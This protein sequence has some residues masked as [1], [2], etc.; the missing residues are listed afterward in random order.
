MSL[1]ITLTA[2]L[3]SSSRGPN[4][5]SIVRGRFSVIRILQKLMGSGRDR[6]P[7]MSWRNKQ[8]LTKGLLSCLIHRLRAPLKNSLTRTFQITI[9]PSLPRSKNRGEE[10][11]TPSRWWATRQWGIRLLCPLRHR[12]RKETGFP[13]T[14]LSLGIE[15]STSKLNRSIK[16]SSM[17]S[18]AI[19]WPSK[20]P[21]CLQTW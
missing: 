10:A 4:T 7:N 5:R 18:S 11:I 15:M 9:P 1:T 13:W 2:P 21:T 12:Q 6:W 14:A 8:S 20:A 17:T 16:R 19:T 3:R